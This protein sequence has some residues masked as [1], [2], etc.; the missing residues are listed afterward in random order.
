MMAL[1]KVI[2]P[3]NSVMMG[4][5]V[6]LSEFIALRSFPSNSLMIHGFLTGFSL[7]GASMVINDIYDYE[8]D[9]INAP[10]RPIPSGILKIK[11]AWIYGL[12]LS[13]LG[14]I[15]AYMINQYCLIIALT[16]FVISIL[17][18]V[19]FKKY[20]LI[21]N[22]MVSFC[23][24]MP[25]IF[26]AYAVG[27][28]SKILLTFS[29]TAFLVNTSREVIKGIADVEGDIKRQVKTVAIEYGIKTARTVAILLFILAIIAAIVPIIFKWVSWLYVPIIMLSLIGLSYEI[30]S[31]LNEINRE[32]AIKI[33]NRLLLYM[34]LALIAMFTGGYYE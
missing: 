19:H 7:T 28:G 9:L 5:S 18:N 16:S 33:K 3:I 12:T 25:F 32:K 14:I 21:G 17:Y 27:G 8:V 6:C 20:G 4:F 11:E 10:K 22:F 29:I 26:G 23:V 15:S 34:F 2:R 13:L 30:L 24:A 1:I 31:L